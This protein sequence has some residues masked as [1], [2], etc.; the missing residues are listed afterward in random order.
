MPRPQLRTRSEKRMKVALPGGRNK[1]HYKKKLASTPCCILCRKPLGGN[2]HLTTVKIHKLNRSKKRVYR[3][4]GG[5]LCHNCLKSA[6]KQ[7]VRIT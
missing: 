4:Y 1:M 7:A 2:P 6:L 5:T 3:P